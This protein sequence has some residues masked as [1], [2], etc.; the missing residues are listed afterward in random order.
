MP[1]D[2]EREVPCGCPA[3][4]PNP[5]QLRRTWPG[6]LLRTVAHRTRTWLASPA[7]VVTWR[8]GRKWNGRSSGLVGRSCKAGGNTGCVSVLLRRQVRP[9]LT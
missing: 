3:G 4:A 7:V 1:M 2:S 9:S 6:I 5:A 8:L